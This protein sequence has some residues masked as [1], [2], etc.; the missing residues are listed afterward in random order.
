MAVRC[1]SYALIPFHLKS[2]RK[3]LLNQQVARFSVNN[4]IFQQI[5]WEYSCLDLTS[6]N[7]GEEATLVDGQS[8]FVAGQDQGHAQKAPPNAHLFEFPRA[9]DYP[10][11]Q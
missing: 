7:V 6:S 10:V 3:G 8:K 2:D 1:D 9:G 11:G 4:S 5:G